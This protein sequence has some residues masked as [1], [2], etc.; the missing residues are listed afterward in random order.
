MRSP[1]PPRPFGLSLAIFAS[2]MLYSLLPLLQVAMVLIVQ[3]RLRNMEL[4][5][6]GGDGEIA[7]LAVG[8]DFTGVP[9]GGLI[10]QTVLAIA[11]LAIAVMAWRGRPSWIR[12]ALIVSVLGLLGLTALSTASTLLTSPTLETGIDSGEPLRQSFQW[13]RLIVSALIALYVLWYMNR[14]PARAFYRGYYLPEAGKTA[15]TD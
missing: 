7:P 1:K 3:L 13:G 14:G 5:I 4:R 12:V 11:F 15:T 2:V 6:P 10:L 8:G 9:S